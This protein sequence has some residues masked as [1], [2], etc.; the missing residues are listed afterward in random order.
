VECNLSLPF[1]VPLRS[2]PP[3][4]SPV[5]WAFSDERA[6]IRLGL[7]LFFAELDRLM[8]YTIVNFLA[9]SQLS[10]LYDPLTPDSVRRVAAV[11][12]PSS[13]PWHE[14]RALRNLLR[15]TQV[16]RTNEELHFVALVPSNS[17]AAYSACCSPHSV[18]ALP[19]SA[20]Q[21]CVLTNRV[22]GGVRKL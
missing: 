12:P 4:S 8:S 21:F 17:S 14:G 22:A 18:L 20:S 5:L 2:H 10:A 11:C 1:T 16:A 3:P 13:L 9:L 6:G 19:I 15:Q 7:P